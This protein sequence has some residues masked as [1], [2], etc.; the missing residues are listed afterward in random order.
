MSNFSWIIDQEIGYG[1]I[2][3]VRQIIEKQ[4]EEL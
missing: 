3:L 4:N 2:S 1:D